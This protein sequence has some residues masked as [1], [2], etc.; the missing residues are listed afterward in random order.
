MALELSFKGKQNFGSRGY[1]MFQECQSRLTACDDTRQGILGIL[2]NSKYPEFNIWGIQRSLKS[3]LHLVNEEIQ[4]I[5]N[6]DG[7]ICRYFQQD[8]DIIQATLQ[9]Y[10]F[11]IVF[12]RP[13]ECC[14]MMCSE[15]WNDFDTAGRKEAFWGNS[16][17]EARTISFRNHEIDLNSEKESRKTFNQRDLGVDALYPF[18]PSFCASDQGLFFL[19]F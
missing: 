12:K 8:S 19:L 9:E 1:E 18:F 16:R 4:A 10:F 11:S 2:E 3:E 14:S 15:N 6:V 5:L 7:T 17:E 13:R